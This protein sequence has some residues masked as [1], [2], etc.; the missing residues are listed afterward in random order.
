MQ[1]HTAG[2]WLGAVVLS[3]LVIALMF[4]PVSLKVASQPMG[5]PADAPRSPTGTES[6]FYNIPAAAF[7]QAGEDTGYFLFSGGYLRGL[8]D[9]SYFMAPVY[10][11][12]Y[13][14]I[15]EVYVSIYDNDASAASNVNLFRVNNSTGI[16]ELIAGTDT[17]EAFNDP[18]I[19]ILSDTTILNPQVIY[20]TYSYYVGINLQSSSVRLYSIRIWYDKIFTYMPLIAK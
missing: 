15:D 2:R 10:L 17:S 7:L 13:A 18:D 16:V 12:N 4:W 19:Q 20:P 6:R 11:P 5:K 3:A 8:T 1:N 9:I 14:T